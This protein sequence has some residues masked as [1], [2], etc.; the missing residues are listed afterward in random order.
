MFFETNDVVRYEKTLYKV[1][2][3]TANGICLS[4]GGDQE[5]WVQKAS[6]ESKLI[7]VRKGRNFNL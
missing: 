7:F 1:K 4:Q 3:D 6:V 5:L 2:T